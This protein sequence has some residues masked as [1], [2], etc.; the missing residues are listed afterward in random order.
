M[1]PMSSQ[2]WEHVRKSVGLKFENDQNL[3]EGLFKQIAAHPLPPLLIQY[4]WGE[5]W[6]F[7]FIEGPR[8]S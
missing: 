3:L 7:A 1:I 4:V 5:A 2:G 8:H 6:E